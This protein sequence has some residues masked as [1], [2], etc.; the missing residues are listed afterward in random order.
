VVGHDRGARCAYRMALDHAEEIRRLALL[1]IVTTADA[2]RGMDM[3]L[4]LGFWVWTLFSAPEPVP[5]RLIAAAPDVIVNHILD[6][7]SATDVFPTEVRS[8]YIAKFRDPDTVHAICE[9]YRAASTLDFAHDEAD[10]GLQRI[11]CPTLV[12]WSATGFL[13]HWPDPL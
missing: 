11:A 8:E 5:E 6:E 3:E 1:D 10:R 7:W 13:T 2:F 9:V 12:L 4:A